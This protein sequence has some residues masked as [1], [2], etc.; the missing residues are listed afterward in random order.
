MIENDENL[1]KYLLQV[2]GSSGKRVASN[3]DDHD[4]YYD[5]DC[6]SESK[7]VSVQRSVEKK[8]RAEVDILGREAKR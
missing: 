7:S 4:D 3:D 8:E 5:D 2:K 1:L 6:W